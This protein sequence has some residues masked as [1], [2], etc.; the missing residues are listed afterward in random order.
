MFSERIRIKTKMIMVFSVI[1]V[2]S[3]I[4]FISAVVYIKNADTKYSQ[5]IDLTETA[6]VQS[7]SFKTGFY[8]MRIDIMKLFVATDAADLANKISTTDSEVTAS[9]AALKSLLDFAAANPWL[10]TSDQISHLQSD[11]NS[12]IGMLPGIQNAIKGGDTNAA[13]A[14]L[15][16]FASYASNISDTLNAA[17]ENSRNNSTRESNRY[18][19]DMWLFIIII[20]SVFAA[21][22]IISII[23]INLVANRISARLGHVTRTLK[24]VARGDFSGGAGS[25]GTDEPSQISNATAVVMEQVDKLIAGINEMSKKLNTEGRIEAAVDASQF[26]G[27]YAE[28]ANGINASIHGVAAILRESAELAGKYAAGDLSQAPSEL[29][30]ERKQ[31]SDGFAG[32]RNTLISIRRDIGAIVEAASG[33]DL[34]KRVEP[35]RYKGAWNE[36]ASGINSLIEGVDKPVTEAIASLGALAGGDLSARI[37]GD[38]EGKFA[39]I[40]DSV[41]AT[42]DSLSLYIGEISRVLGSM[43]G[44]DFDIDVGAG[45]DFMGDFAPIKTALNDIL[46]TFGD[47]LK[48]I[49]ASA[50]QVADSAKHIA[51]SSVGIA[52]GATQQ[53]ASIETLARGVTEMAKRSEENSGNAKTASGHA[54][55]VK[56][57]AQVADTEMSQMLNAMGAIDETSAN[58]SKI[59]KVIEDIAFQTNL[60]AL[61][62]AVEAARAGQHGKGFAVVAEEVRSLAL[63]SQEAASETNGLI[64]GS[65][66][67][68]REG[69][70][71]A[72][73]TAETMRQIT[74]KI[75]DISRIISDVAGVS[76]RQVADIGRINAGISQIQE[77]TQ[78]NTAA[79]EEEA[80]ASQELS[81]QAEVFRSIVSKFK[82][83]EDRAPAAR[84]RV[85]TA[86]PADANDTAESGDQADDPPRDIRA[87]AKPAEPPAVS[88]PVR[89]GSPE[90]DIA[91]P[92][93]ERSDF[94]K[95]S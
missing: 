53:A 72:N 34:S 16:T 31:L 26:E 29:A 52:Q 11:Y 57:F 56:Q 80:S 14:M 58:I 68:V 17:T 91:A 64:E 74:G 9:D 4:M 23:L 18:T 90:P 42:M 77:V 82:L 73:Q 86:A 88:A 47:I 85:P 49:S 41:N 84:R 44:R 2:L 25:D 75:N 20:L 21:S 50:E 35:G 13:I 79:S 83:R 78:V 76:E 43:S 48:E 66:E 94:G 33:G 65:A 67:R 32:L 19:A 87:G 37:T 45:M 70:K 6:I 28:V 63:R 54:D 81:S 59:I 5:L 93:Y 60:L 40:K 39:E 55:D 36:L 62:A 69:K 10:L 95:Y 89:S 8:Q 92:E 24:G 22:V 12:Y 7:E 27:A 30:G 38:Y 3:C 46:G 15:N 61:N 1:L 51:D 71:I